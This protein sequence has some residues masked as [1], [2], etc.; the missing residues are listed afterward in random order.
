MRNPQ[1][2]IFLATELVCLYRVH[3][4]MRLVFDQLTVQ[5]ATQNLYLQAFNSLLE[6]SR[7]ECLCT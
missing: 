3:P 2:S 5:F 4:L 1:R 7:V 6:T